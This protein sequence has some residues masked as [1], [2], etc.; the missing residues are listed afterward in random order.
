M[1]G[2]E[3]CAPPNRSMYGYQQR[4]ASLFIQLRTTH[5]QSAFPM[6]CHKRAR[7]VAKFVSVCVESV[8][9]RTCM[10]A[11]AAACRHTCSRMWIYACVVLCA[12]QKR[13]MM[14][15]CILQHSASLFIQ[16]TH[17]H[18]PSWFPMGCPTHTWQNSWAWGML[19]RGQKNPLP[20]LLRGAEPLLVEHGQ[21]M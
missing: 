2:G 6:G 5:D 21:L 9:M 8:C 10:H 16:V 11:H 19:A 15:A 7:D 3:C 1:Q 20:M 13:L 14:H 12:V 4:S 18:D 17:T